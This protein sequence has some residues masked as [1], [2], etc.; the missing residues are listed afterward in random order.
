MIIEAFA[1]CGKTY[2]LLELAN[3]LSTK[4]KWAYLVFNTKN[5]EE[6]QEKFP[7]NIKASTFNK[8][9][10]DLVEKATNMK[11]MKFGSSKL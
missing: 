4:E 11:R 8:F 7:S 6:A 2:T 3:T 9:C 1:G 10:G 5:A